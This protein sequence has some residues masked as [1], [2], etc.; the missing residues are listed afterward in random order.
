MKR[1]KQPCVIEDNCLIQRL[2]VNEGALDA[3]AGGEGVLPDCRRA[4]AKVAAFV[5]CRRNRERQQ[6]RG[7]GDAEET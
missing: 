7:N 4:L 1:Q 5:C 6:E 2:A 3:V